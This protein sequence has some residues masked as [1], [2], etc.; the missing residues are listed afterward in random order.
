MVAARISTSS[1]LSRG[2]VLSIID[3]VFERGRVRRDAETPERDAH[4]VVGEHRELAGIVERE[5]S[6]TPKAGVELPQQ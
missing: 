3:S 1:S 5:I 6:R 2:D 4:D